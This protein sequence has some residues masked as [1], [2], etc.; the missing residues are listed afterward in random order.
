MVVR[1]STSRA[2]PELDPARP[3]M[4]MPAGDEVRPQ[5]TE[6]VLSFHFGPD[7]GSATGM[8]GTP[9]CFT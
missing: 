8:S 1:G 9:L 5:G 6:K 7:G 3:G 2:V 4:V